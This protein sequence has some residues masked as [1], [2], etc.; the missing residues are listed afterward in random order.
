[1]K[2]RCGETPWDGPPMR[3]RTVPA[4][5]IAPFFSDLSVYWFLAR[6]S[7]SEK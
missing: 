4:I 6:C 7:V 3:P 1:M 2:Y 5:T